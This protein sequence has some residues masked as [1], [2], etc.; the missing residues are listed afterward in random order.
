[1]PKYVAKASLNQRLI[2]FTHK[3]IITKFR[4][5]NPAISRFKMPDK[6]QQPSMIFQAFSRR[7]FAQQMNV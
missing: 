1:V 6:A 5:T 7:I 3:S 2:L 4:H